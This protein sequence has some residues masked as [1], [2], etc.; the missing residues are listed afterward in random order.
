MFVKLDAY[1]YYCLE[2]EIAANTIKNYMMT[3]N[4]LNDFLDQTEISEVTKDD[5][6]NFKQHLKEDDYAPGKKYKTNTCNQ[7]ITAINIYLNWLERPELK[8]KLFKEQTT[9]HRESISQDDFERFLRYAD[10]EMKLF[11]LLIRNY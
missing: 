11:V 10:K 3:L 5:L 1:R 8:L 9:N 6:I 2:N 7:K 4:Q